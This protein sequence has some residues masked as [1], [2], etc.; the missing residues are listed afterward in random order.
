MNSTERTRAAK[1][2]ASEAKP[3]LS[4]PYRFRTL[5]GALLAGLALGVSGWLI[6]ILNA[7]T[8]YSFQGGAPNGFPL[9]RA[10]TVSAVYAIGAVLGRI[11]YQATSGRWDASAMA[12]PLFACITPMISWNAKIEAG[13][14]LLPSLAAPALVMSFFV[15][16]LSLVGLWNRRTRHR[17]TPSVPS[18]GG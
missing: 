1:P 18:P 15:S 12:I 4:A 10:A 3:S 6:G 7:R 14:P 2:Q 17:G 11:V 9:A 5:R 8:G 16:V 13:N